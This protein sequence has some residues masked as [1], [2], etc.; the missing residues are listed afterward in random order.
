MRHPFGVYIDCWPL[1][2]RIYYIPNGAEL[3][4]LGVVH[5]VRGFLVP[6]EK[7]KKVKY[8]VWCRV[9]ATNA[10]GRTSLSLLSHFAAI[11]C[12][13]CMSQERVCTKREILYTPATSQA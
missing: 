9:S 12:A 11:M 4:M 1:H 5:V 13:E 2:D 3:V 6:Q 7:Q 8:P 10:E